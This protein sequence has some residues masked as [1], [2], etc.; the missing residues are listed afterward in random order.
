[1]MVYLVEME[2]EGDFH[3]RELN[4]DVVTD[5]PE[6]WTIRRSLEVTQEDVNKGKV[7]LYGLFGITNLEPGP[8]LP[9][10]PYYAR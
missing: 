3:L 8:G 7:H 4:I 10:G 9:R 5:V 2:E 1:M 6:G